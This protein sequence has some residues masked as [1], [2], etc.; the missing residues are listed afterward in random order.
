MKR[1]R[2]DC[3]TLCRSD[4]ADVIVPF[5]IHTG[6]DA[7]S[8]FYGHGK[9]SIFDTAMKSEEARKLLQGLGKRLPVTADMQDDMEQFTIRYIYNDKTGK[10]LAEARAKKW[11]V[12]KKKS[13]LRIPPDSDSHNMK[14]TRANNQ[15]FRFPTITPTTW[16]VFER[17]KMCTYTLHTACSA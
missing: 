11:E 14:V 3:K 8:S 13:T 4:V 6:A 10:R 2:Y 1:V 15:V 9:P 7:V 12:M 16:L 5:H 17:G